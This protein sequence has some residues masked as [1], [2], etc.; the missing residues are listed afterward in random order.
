MPQQTT[1]THQIQKCSK[2][3]LQTYVKI[4][5]KVSWP[6]SRCFSSTN[7]LRPAILSSAK[8]SKSP[9]GFDQICAVG[10]RPPLGRSSNIHGGMYPGDID[11]TF[12]KG[13]IQSIRCK[14][15]AIQSKKGTL[16]LLRSASTQGSHQLAAVRHS[17][18]LFLVVDSLTCRLL[19]RKSYGH[20]EHHGRIIECCCLQSFVGMSSL[21]EE[22]FI[23]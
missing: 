17:F 16:Q 13:L 15:P 3:Q 5:K 9:A 11:L 8:R 21:P 23:V 14:T 12:D 22:H 6:F 20:V 7:C 1:N 18:Y 19:C 10:M 4:V 2:D